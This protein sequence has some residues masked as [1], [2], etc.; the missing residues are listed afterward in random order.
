MM[1]NLFSRPLEQLYAAAAL[2]A[3]AVAANG[4]TSPSSSTVVT[5]SLQS[6]QSNN[7]NPLNLL[8]NAGAVLNNNLLFNHMANNP[9]NPARLSV[10]ELAAA[11]QAHALVQAQQQQQ[12]QQQSSHNY[13]PQQF[14]FS[15]HFLPF[16]PNQSK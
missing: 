6:T 7:T 4:P 14:Q 5:S 16:H 1:A 9:T 13:L 2:A 11:A 10:A 8:A 3:A 15:N 12:H